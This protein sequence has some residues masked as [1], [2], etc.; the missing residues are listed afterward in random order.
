MNAQ[1]G[2]ARRHLQ[3]VAVTQGALRVQIT[4]VPVLMH[5][6]GAELVVLRLRLIRC[7]L[8]YQLQDRRL[9][10]MGQPSLQFAFVRVQLVAGY[11]R[12]QLLGYQVAVMSLPEVIGDEA[13]AA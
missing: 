3:P 11:F 1:S 4:A 13:R 10:H 6:A 8:V 5:R 9:R 2:V 7:L 12:Q